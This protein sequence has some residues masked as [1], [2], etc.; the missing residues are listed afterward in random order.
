MNTTNRYHILWI[1]LFSIG[2][3][4]SLFMITYEGE[5]GAIPLILLVLGGGGLI[6][7][8]LM[9]TKKRA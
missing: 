3:L 5:P 7:R 2:M 4:L 6:S 8:R 1:T 9:N